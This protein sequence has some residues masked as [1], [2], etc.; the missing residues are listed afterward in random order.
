MKRLFYIVLFIAVAAVLLN[1]GGRLFTARSA[2]NSG[3][4]TLTTWASGSA[5]GLNGNQVAGQLDERGI[6]LGIDVYQYALVENGVQI[7]TQVRVEGL[8]V[9]G[10]YKSMLVG[11]P[12]RE[13]MGAP[14]TLSQYSF[15]DYW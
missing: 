14:V 5:K 9:W 10:T 7:W 8:W 2:L 12:F 4:D 6:A 13:A 3:T 1:D 11:V 15:A